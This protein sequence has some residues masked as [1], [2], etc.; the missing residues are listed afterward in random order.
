MA[1]LTCTATVSCGGGSGAQK[2][3]EIKEIAVTIEPLRYFAEK[4]AGNDYRFFSVVPPGQGPETY[5]P[6]PREMVRVGKAV[7]F[8]HIGRLPIEKAIATAMRQNN[9]E[10]TIADVSEQFDNQFVD[11]HAHAENLSNLSN[12]STACDKHH[13]DPH[14]WTSLTGAR[15]IADNFYKTFSALNA[16]RKDFYHSNYQS[17]I[18][19]LDALSDTIHALMDTLSCRSFV[20]YHPALTYLAKEFDFRQLSIEDDG[21]EPSPASMKQLIEHSREAGVRVVF[22][23]KEFDAK[24]AEQIAIS[25]GAKL[26][27]INTLDYQW[28]NEIL[29]IVKNLTKN[30]QTD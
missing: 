26:I 16:S 2:S 3:D 13:N 18:K 25:T 9:S 8:M 4:I 1:V 7:A 11:C 15:I 28:Y 6:T 23:Q 20:I 27:S 10:I 24:Y 19:E 5:D 12:P 21:K 30:G 14:I 22:V 29:F 17:F